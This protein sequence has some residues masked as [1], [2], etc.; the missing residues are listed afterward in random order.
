MVRFRGETKIILSFSN[1]IKY[2]YYKEHRDE[3]KPYNVI[4]LLTRYYVQLD[5]SNTLGSVLPC[6]PLK[7]KPSCPNFVPI[8]SYSFSSSFVFDQFY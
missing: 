6:T 4:F 7:T 3:L 1:R 2:S 5:H 8:V